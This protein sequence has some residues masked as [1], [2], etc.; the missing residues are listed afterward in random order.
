MH[1]TGAIG[2]KDP[3][4]RL[5]CAG[6]DEE[7]TVVANSDGHGWVPSVTE[8]AD[9]EDLEAPVCVA[10]FLFRDCLTSVISMTSCSTFVVF[11]VCHLWNVGYWIFP[12]WVVQNHFWASKS[13]FSRKTPSLSHEPRSIWLFFHLWTF[14]SIVCSAMLWSRLCIKYSLVL[15][16]ANYFL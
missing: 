1:V 5:F 3:R 4:N 2:N 12:N 10:S 14:P 13:P 16:T 11:C 9:L 7:R 15:H 8:P 6:F